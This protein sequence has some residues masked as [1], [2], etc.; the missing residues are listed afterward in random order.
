MSTN[1]LA[2]IARS[3]LLVDLTIS[4]YSGR[5]QDRAT[6]DEVTARKGAG[7]KRAASV[8][9]SLFADCPELDAI[10]SFQG[11]LRID[12][13][14]LTKPWSDS[15]L[16]LVPYSL[17]E[18]HRDLM[19]DAEREFWKLVEAF[20]DKFETLVAA[21]AFKLGALFDRSEYPTREQVRRKFGFYLTYTPL[22][23][24][25]DFRIDIENEVQRDLIKQFDDAMVERER[26]LMKDSWDR[27][28]S[29]LSRFVRQLA[30]REGKRARIFDSMIGDARDLCDLL[31]HFNVNGD[32]ALERARKQLEDMIEGVTT[33]ALRTEEDTRAAIHNQAKA[34][35]DAYEWGMGEDTELADAA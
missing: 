24:A 22:P 33:D 5:I 7:S 20:L 11:K 18:R 6:R 23:K 15:G 25:G 19:Y 34:I 29:S 17:L 4:T 21:A 14:R 26:V 16:R 2:G 13:Y 35:L 32:P 12:H 28:H 30:P 10:T 3:S 31:A 8:Y 9:K 27:L 1:A